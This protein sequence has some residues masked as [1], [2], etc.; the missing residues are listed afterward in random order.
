MKKSALKIM[1]LAVIAG[2]IVTLT[3][4]DNNSSNIDKDEYERIMSE[5]EAMRGQIGGTN[6]ENL[7]ASEE[8]NKP[9]ETERQNV[10]ETHNL[11]T[12]ESVV[13]LP[14]IYKTPT[15]E[16]KTPE[17]FLETRTF[18]L[19]NAMQDKDI[20]FKMELIEGS[21]KALTYTSGSNVYME[22][23]ESGKTH[24]VLFVNGILYGFDD[25]DMTCR[26]Y[27]ISDEQIEEMLSTAIVDLK[28]TTLIVAGVGDYRG[29]ERYFEELKDKNGEIIRY[30]F[31][32]S[33]DAFIGAI[34]DGK[35]AIISLT[36]GVPKNAFEIP[37]GYE[38]IDMGIFNG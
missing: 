33:K 16:F 31:N 8:R 12:E 22:L 11:K 10:E 18:A 26:F 14:D 34:L 9:S 24:R 38:M 6:S 15:N 30:I 20:T 37:G 1:A 7:T 4:C 3:A 19:I 25:S 23:S 17:T 32:E 29:A 35:M 5:N 28:N 2:I 36:V 21:E 13:K 27:S